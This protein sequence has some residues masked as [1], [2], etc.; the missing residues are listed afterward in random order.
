MKFTMYPGPWPNVIEEIAAA[1][2][3][4]VSDI[5]EA[6][7]LIYNGGPGGLP[8]PLPESIGFIQYPFAGVNHL[9][10]SGTV[11]PDVRWANAGGVY[12]RPVAEIALSLLLSQMHQIKA[13][14]MSGSFRSRNALD[15]RQGWLFDNAKVA[16][17]GAGG[18]GT[19]L[20]ELLKPFGVHSIAVNRSGR[21]VAGADETFAMAEAGHVWS[22][23][24]YFVLTA[25]LTEETRGLVNDEVLAQMKPHAVLVNVGRGELVVTDDLVAALTQ[26][27]IAG[28][29]MD[30]TDP[31]PLPESHPLW[32]LPNCTILPHIAAT[33]R[34][35]Q[36]MVAPQIIANAAA[37]E[38]GERMPTEV[39]LEAGY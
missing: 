11:Q 21:P 7:F 26:G 3:T 35:A 31:E 38:V 5:R 30:V 34:I 2:H 18:I 6:E 29:A 20:I 1:G 25:P 9:V 10:E 8:S 15:A 28:A 22:E 24:D 14:T 37:F 16:L 32:A 36:K 12:G 39:D 4:Y 27:T 13:A 17:I 33:G 19:A 23:A